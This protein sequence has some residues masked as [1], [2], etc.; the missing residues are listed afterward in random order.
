MNSLMTN[1]PTQV[2]ILLT[3]EWPKS[4]TRFSKIPPTEKEIGGSEFVS[5]L[6]TKIKPRYHFAASEKIFYKREP[7]QNVPSPNLISDSEDTQ[8]QL[9]LPTWFVGFAEVDNESKGKV[10]SVF[11]SNFLSLSLSLLKKS[12]FN[13]TPCLITNTNY[14]LKYFVINLVVLRFQPCTLYTFVTVD[15]HESPTKYDGMSFSQIKYWSKKR[16]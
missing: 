9:G 13:L 1:P 12:L 3:Y 8:L 11:S 5:L 7:Y 10:N 14:T 2:D 6:A 15:F 16:I 4:I